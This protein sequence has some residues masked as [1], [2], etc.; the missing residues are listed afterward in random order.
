MYFDDVF[1]SKNPATGRVPAFSTA[2]N[3]FSPHRRHG[4]A[5]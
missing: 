2:E 4:V 1:A 3:L 5:G